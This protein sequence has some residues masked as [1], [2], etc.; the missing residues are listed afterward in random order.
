MPPARPREI[1]AFAETA[2]RRAR[3]LGLT[4]DECR[5]LRVL[6]LVIM[7]QGFGIS[8]PRQRT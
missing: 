2:G 4:E 6:A 8:L 5:H 1:P 3:A 7:N